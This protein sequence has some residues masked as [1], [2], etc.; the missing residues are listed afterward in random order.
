[1]SPP[2]GLVA[3]TIPE[4]AT[5][6]TSEFA[7]L[8]GRGEPRHHLGHVVEARDQARATAERVAGWQDDAPLRRIERTQRRMG[9]VERAL[10]VRC[11]DRARHDEI[12]RAQR[13]ELF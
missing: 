5:R 8:P 7:W 6:K 3:E 4:R 13:H 9:Q 12:V 1:M 11:L 2:V 10:T